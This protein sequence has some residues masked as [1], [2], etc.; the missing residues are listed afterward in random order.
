[1]PRGIILFGSPGSGTTTL[2]K[3]AARQLGFKHFDLD[4]YLW[5]WDTEVPYTVLRAKEERVER[6]MDE[7]SRYSNFI[8]SGSMWSIRKSFEPLFDLAVYVTAPAEI[9]A[10][11]LRARSLSRWGDRVLPGGDMYEQHAAYRDYLAAAR[12][13]DTDESPESYRKQHEQLAVELHC[14]VLRVDGAGEISENTERIVERYLQIYPNFI[15][16]RS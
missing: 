16:R 8:M 2:G 1:M 12:Q 13:Y 5:R 14:P 4:D 11:R 3:E 9:R 15:S 6:L 10:E 7:I